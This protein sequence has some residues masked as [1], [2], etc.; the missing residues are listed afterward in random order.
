MFIR[1]LPIISERKMQKNK[2]PNHGLKKG[3]NAIELKRVDITMLKLLKLNSYKSTKDSKKCSTTM[4][5]VAWMRF[6]IW[7]NNSF[8]SPKKI[9]CMTVDL[10]LKY[11]TVM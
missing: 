1:W 8:L 6:V 2:A 5:S 3:T 9:S 10:G 4:N 7:L 11:D